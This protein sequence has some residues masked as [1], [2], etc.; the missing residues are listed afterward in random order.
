MRVGLVLFYFGGKVGRACIGYKEKDKENK[1]RE[2]FRRRLDFQHATRFVWYHVNV[3]TADDEWLLDGRLFYI[4]CGWTLLLCVWQ[5]VGTCTFWQGPYFR[6]GGYRM[7]VD[8]T[9]RAP[10]LCGYNSLPRARLTGYC[11]KNTYICRLALV[12]GRPAVRRVRV[13]RQGCQKLAN[14]PSC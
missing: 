3:P 10:K 1:R 4:F 14:V 2:H 6:Y 7:T 11:G 5:A 12:Q 9:G 8:P 13:G